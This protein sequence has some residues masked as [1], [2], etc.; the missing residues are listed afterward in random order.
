LLKRLAQK[1]GFGFAN[2]ASVQA[3]LADQGAQCRVEAR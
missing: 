3:L 1:D 2:F